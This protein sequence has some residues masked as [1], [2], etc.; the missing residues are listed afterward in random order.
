PC[1]HAVGLLLLWTG[2]DGAVPSARAPEWAEQWLSTRRGKADGKERA[3]TSGPGSGSSSVD[4]QAALRRA[5]RR[6]ERI[7]AGATELEQRL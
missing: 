5:E 6:A 3:G 2:G 4:P 1:K 7:S